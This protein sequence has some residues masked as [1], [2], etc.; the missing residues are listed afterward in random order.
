MFTINPSKIKNAIALLKEFE[1]FGGY[2]LAFSGGKDSICIYH[3]AKMAG[4]KF[5]AYFAQTTV[6]PPDVL[7]FIKKYFPDVVFLRPE[8]SLFQIIEQKKMLPTRI[9]AYCCEFLKEYAGLG[10]FI[11]QG[12]RW[13]ESHKRSKRNFF[14]IDTRKKMKGKRYLNPI[15]DWTEKDVWS[16]IKLNKLPFP[17]L[18]LGCHSRIGCIGCPKAYYKHRQREFELYPRFKRAYILAIKRAM[19]KGGFR[20][21]DSPE[22]VFNWWLSNKSKKVWNANKMQRVIEF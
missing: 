13:E 12:I 10:N 22:D 15:I 6:D 16:F 4:I 2:H 19:A 5:T 9:R 1:P 11:L 7:T 18:Y 20:D 8:R 3:L 21:F 14:E 17:D